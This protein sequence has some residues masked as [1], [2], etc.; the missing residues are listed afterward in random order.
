ML[1]L[2]RVLY[3]FP[4]HDSGE[5]VFGVCFVLPITPSPPCLHE[6]VRERGSANWKER[7]WGEEER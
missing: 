4:R 2:H 3:W 7:G 6:F 1:G 5:S